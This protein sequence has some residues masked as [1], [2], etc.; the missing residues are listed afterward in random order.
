MNEI[1]FNE[2]VR[3]IIFKPTTEIDRVLNQVKFKYVYL[4]PVLYALLGG[5]SLSFDHGTILLSTISSRLFFTYLISFIYSW[6]VFFISNSLKGSAN[7]NMTYGL[8][9][10]SFIPLILGTTLFLLLK[11]LFAICGVSIQTIT[12]LNYF[13]YYS[14]IIF[15]IWTLFLLVIGNAYIN[16]FSILRSFISSAGYILLRIFII[17][18]K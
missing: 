1:T 9:S 3:I 11:I 5:L 2:I 18:K 12:L 16:S 13:I 4:F 6:I 10:Y 17:L 8:I 15:L 7:I 14:Q